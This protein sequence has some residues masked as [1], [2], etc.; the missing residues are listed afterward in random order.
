MSSNGNGARPSRRQ[1]IDLRDLEDVPGAAPLGA[2]SG[3]SHA[4]HGERAARAAEAT[5]L[6]A[7]YAEYDAEATAV[8]LADDPELLD[9]DEPLVGESDPDENLRRYAWWQAKDFLRTRAVWLLPLGI[10]ALWIFRDNYDPSEVA[11]RI[12]EQAEQMRRARNSYVPESE[13]EKFRQIVLALGGV[14]AALGSLIS[15]LG[16]VARDRERGLQRFLFAKPVSVTRFYLQ[17]FLIHGV[18]TM[19]VLAL[20]LGFTAVAFFRPVPFLEPMLM[21]ACAYA[22]IGGFTF[23]LSTLVRF[24]FAASGI[25]SVL[26][27]PVYGIASESGWRYPL[28][29]VGRWLLPPVP[30]LA[31][32]VEPS[33]HIVPG[34]TWGAVAFC[35][36]YG[37]AY[38]AG[39]LAVLRRRSITT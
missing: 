3:A 14:G 19:A 28:A 15:T 13:P 24:D 23:L 31:Q 11:R 6:D 38:L 29:A 18:G 27:I 37:A 4:A 8:A 20:L 39:G 2:R 1:S 22:L 12:A 16:I 33:M 17:S 26:S 7:T 30:A 10:L 9:R 36:A 34:G 25:L 32:I 5:P 35:L 21:G